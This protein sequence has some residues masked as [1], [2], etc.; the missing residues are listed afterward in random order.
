[1]G[2]RNQQA[3]NILIYFEP[4]VCDRLSVG[5]LLPTASVAREFAGAGF[6]QHEIPA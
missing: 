2:Q 4:I 6:P 3:R 1:V 5:V